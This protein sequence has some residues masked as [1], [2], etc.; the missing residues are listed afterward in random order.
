L[1]GF[2]GFGLTI[3][4]VFTEGMVAYDPKR[5]SDRADGRRMALLQMK[6]LLKTGGASD[7]HRP[8]DTDATAI[9]GSLLE[10]TA[11]P[12]AETRPS[13]ALGLRTG[14]SYGEVL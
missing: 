1:I 9:E 5:T 2:T 14:G 7:K 10:V 4:L 13:A 6:A 11:L 12:T 8:D 3:P